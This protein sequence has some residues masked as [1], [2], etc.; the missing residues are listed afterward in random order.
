MVALRVS[1]GLADME[2]MEYWSMS[3]ISRSVRIVLLCLF[4]VLVLAPSCGAQQAA[5]SGQVVE[6]GSDRPVAKIKL[7]LVRVSQ[8]GAEE[9]DQPI[10]FEKVIQTDDQ[11]RFAFRVPSNLDGI[12]EVIL[13]TG[14]EDH[15]NQ[16]YNGVEFRGQ[17]PLLR[18]AQREGVVRLDLSKDVKDVRIALQPIAAPAKQTLMLPM[19]DGTKLATDIYLPEGQGPWPVVLS[20]T[21]YNKNTAKPARFLREGYAMVFQDF[22]GRFASEGKDMPFLP[23]GWGEHQDGYDT[24]EWIAKQPWSNGKVGTLGGSA[25]GITQVMTAGARPPHLVCQTITVACGSLYHHAAYIGG[26]FG[27]SLLEGWLQG[28]KFSPDCLKTMV[29]NPDYNDLWRHM[30]ASTRSAEIH[31]PGLFSGGWFDVFNQGTIDA[32]LWRQNNGGEGAKGRQKIVMG[33]WP[34]GRKQTVGEL[35]FPP[36]SMQPPDGSDPMLWLAYWLKGEQNGIMDKPAVMYYTMGDVDDKTAPGN[37]WRTSDVWPVPCRE[38]PY[39]LCADGRLSTEKPPADAKPR[40]Y[41][42]DPKNPVPTKGGCNLNIPAGPFGQREIEKRP[43]VL[44]YTTEALDRPVEVTGRVKAVLWASSSCK[45]TDFTAKL[46]DVYPDGRSML[47]LDGILRARHRN[48][49]EKEEMMTPGE[50]YRLEIDLWSTSL[51]FN[52]GHKIRLAVSSSNF[53]RFDA[54]PNTGDPFRA[55]SNTVVAENTI[56]QDAE[57]PSHVLLPIVEAKQ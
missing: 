41:K 23:D 38:T 20:R 40:S 53:P 10:R 22:R 16:I 29:E 42:Y 35:T 15:A 44:V 9:P 3:A 47:V 30:D 45:D 39:Y 14:S 36:N 19:R 8:L 1:E 28:N 11:G 24:I 6:K 4:A 46:T 34:H 21:P 32:F 27:K 55:N 7:G 49:M 50:V 31:V 17:L 52:R 12:R 51:I 25:L 57:H 33:P 13:F 37:A 26:A 5:L 54:N 18:D 48:S 43:D 56:R 2:S